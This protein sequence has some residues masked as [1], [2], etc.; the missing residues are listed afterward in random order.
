MKKN[1]FFSMIGVLMAFLAVTAFIFVSCDSFLIPEDPVTRTNPEDPE[2]VDPNAPTTYSV[3]YDANGGTGA[4]VDAA[5]HAEGDSVTV[6]DP[7]SMTYD[8]HIF[9]NWECSELGAQIE[10]DPGDTFTMPAEDITF[11]AQWIPDIVQLLA[12]DYSV[13]ND[14][15]GGAVAIDGDYAVVGAPQVAIVDGAATYSYCGAVYVFH[16]T[17]LDTWDEGFTIESPALYTEVYFGRSVDI[18]GD[19]LIV[20]APGAFSGGVRGGIA[21]V[22]HRT[23][24]NTWELDE[25]FSRSVAAADDYFGCSVGLGGEFAIVGA[26]YVTGTMSAQGS[27]KIYQR[28]AGVW[29]G[30]LEVEG[31]PM[32]GDNFGYAVAVN[33]DWAVIGARYGD[34]AAAD[35]GKVYVYGNTGGNSWNPDSTLYHETATNDLNFGSS[36]DLDGSR[37]VVGADQMTVGG[38]TQSGGAF[39]YTLVGATWGTYVELDPGV[40]LESGDCFGRSVAVS[41]DYI[42]V[43]ALGRDTDAENGGTAYIFHIDGSDWNVVSTMGGENQYDYLGNSVGITVEPD[44]AFCLAGAYGYGGGVGDYPGAAYV[45]LIP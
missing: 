43:G 6:L 7:G 2:Y 42:I 4:P 36:V 38:I 19:Y 27:V 8:G 16:R 22:Y 44:G 5:T 23:D 9:V 28:A 12:A 18:E 29:D 13:D 14:Q 15:F 1:I 26:C 45:H 20:G 31:P 24:T 25:I 10:Y 39:V 35:T 3:T 11:T 34:G 21:Y 41:G 33:D 30:G 37:I 17:G 32:P 40:T